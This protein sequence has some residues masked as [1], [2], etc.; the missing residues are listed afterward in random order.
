LG[1]LKLFSAEGTG[2]LFS[3]GGTEKLLITYRNTNLANFFTY[4][5][6]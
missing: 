2:K 1:T 3:M 6:I 4:H 5:W